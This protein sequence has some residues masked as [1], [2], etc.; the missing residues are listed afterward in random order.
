MGM[1][2]FQNCYA[3]NYSMDVTLGSFPKADTSF[4]SDNVIYLNSASGQ[5]VPWIDTKTATIY[6]KKNNKDTDTEFIVPGN[7]QRENPYFDPN[8]TFK[9]ADAQFTILTRPS[10]QE[11]DMEFDFET[12]VRLDE[13]KGTREIDNTVSYIGAKSLKITSLDASQDGARGGV[14]TTLPSMELNTYYSFTMY[15]KTNSTQ[16][17][18]VIVSAKNPDQS[19]NEFNTFDKIEFNQGWV[20]IS[21]TFKITSYKQ[22]LFIY[23]TAANVILWLDEIVLR[24]EPENP[25]LKF[26]TDLM[27]S[28]KL[29][30]PLSR[31]NISCLGHKY[32]A[33]RPLSLQ[34]I[35]HFCYNHNHWIS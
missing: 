34:R 8:Y 1:I 6:N 17:I 18:D 2:V 16:E 29:N 10:A 4:I 9:P 28:F 3:S 35:L 33:D 25:P 5:H 7:Y 13:Y 31:Q 12:D 32:Y 14:K 30:V 20:R 11:I 19:T 15:A 27:Q 22:D 26:H 21:K 23:T 24:K